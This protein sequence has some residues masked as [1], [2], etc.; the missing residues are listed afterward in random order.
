MAT[1]RSATKDAAPPVVSEDIA[2]AKDSEAEAR[3]EKLELALSQAIDSNEQTYD[4]D[5]FD[6]EDDDVDDDVNKNKN[7]DN[8]GDDNG[9]EDSARK[10]EVQKMEKL[11]GEELRKLSPVK[12]A[13]RSPA[14]SVAKDLVKMALDDSIGAEEA[15]EAFEAA[16]AA[17]KKEEDEAEAAAKAEKARIEAEAKA[18][19]EEEE[20]KSKAEAERRRIEAR[21]KMKEEL[22]KQLMNEMVAEDSQNSSLDLSLE[23]GA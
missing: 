12:A 3:G 13:P 6:D 2:A 5:D 1:E 16:K 10:D 17:A 7:H 15:N 19:R 8:D 14:V 20:R 4:D 11:G 9:M 22:R 21:E 18:K 23:D